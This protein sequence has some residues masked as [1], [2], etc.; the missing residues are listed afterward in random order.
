MEL[1]SIMKKLLFSVIALVAFTA[2]GMASEISSEITTKS[3]TPCADRYEADMNE[4][5]NDYCAT[6]EIADAIATREFNEC[7]RDTYGLD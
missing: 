2:T 6:F 5:M 7:L 3:D 4:L 1:T